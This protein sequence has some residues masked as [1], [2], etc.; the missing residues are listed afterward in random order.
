MEK[1]NAK[2]NGNNT[3]KA[4]STPYDDVFRTLLN[5]CRNLILPVLNEVF[6]EEYTGEEEIVPTSEIHYINQQDGYE[7]KRIT[8]SSFKVIGKEEKKFLC[9]CQ[10]TADSSMLVRIFE[11]VTQIALDEGELAGNTLT[12]EFPHSMVLFLRSTKKTPDT[13]TIEMKTPGGTVCFGVPVMKAQSYS[14][15]EIFQKKLLFLLPFYIFSYESR[16]KEYNENEEKLEALKEEYKEIVQ[17]LEQLTEQQEIS[18]YTKKTIIEMSEKVLENLARNYQQVKEGVCS[19]MG[20]Q[21]L[22]YEAKTILLKG[23][24]EGRREGKKE[25]K[26]E[27]KLEQARKTAKNLQKLGLEVDAIAEMIEVEVE[28]VRQ[29]LGV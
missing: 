9:E 14:L 5:D 3:S 20:G 18:V 13:M 12:V 15:E 11:Y 16:L 1:K 24:E 26:T 22:E 25:G 8:D 17:K 4:V 23:K 21:I 29:W 2:E 19:V 28:L 10:S 27:G 7:E 6:G